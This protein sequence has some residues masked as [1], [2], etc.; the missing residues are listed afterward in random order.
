ML[1]LLLY[2]SVLF[3]TYRHSQPH[4]NAYATLTIMHLLIQLAELEIELRT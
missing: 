4:Y 1:A 3:S 2:S